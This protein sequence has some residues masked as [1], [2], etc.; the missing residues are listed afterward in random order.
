[1]KPWRGQVGT[2]GVAVPVR[3]SRY[4]RRCEVAGPKARTLVG[5]SKAKLNIALS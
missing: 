5:E 1:M 4:S 3:P 2:V